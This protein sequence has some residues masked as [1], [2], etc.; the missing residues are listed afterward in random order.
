MKVP[1]DTYYSRLARS[2]NLEPLQPKAPFPSPESER[3]FR[4]LSEGTFT[5]VLRCN[6]EKHACQI[7]DAFEISAYTDDDCKE[8]TSR[9]TIGRRYNFSAGESNGFIPE[10]WM[11][12]YHREL[13]SQLN[14]RVL[15]RFFR[16][17]AHLLSS[18]LRMDVYDILKATFM[19]LGQW[20]DL[21]DAAIAIADASLNCNHPD[22]AVMR[23]EAGQA[24]ETT[25]RFAEAALVFKHIGHKLENND[26]TNSSGCI[27]TPL[28]HDYTAKA[29]RR[30][31]KKHTAANESFLTLKAYYKYYDYKGRLLDFSNAIMS[32]LW[33]TLFSLLTEIFDEYTAASDNRGQECHQQAFVALSGLLSTAGFSPGETESSKSFDQR[34]KT[35]TG[36]LHVY[37]KSSRQAAANALAQGIKESQSIEDFQVSLVKALDPQVVKRAPLSFA[38]HREKGGLP[39]KTQKDWK[40][41]T[42]TDMMSGLV[43]CN[44]GN[45]ITVFFGCD[46]SACRR[47]GKNLTT[48]EASTKCLH[49]PCHW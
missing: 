47:G 28:I 24:L 30:A 22:C 9:L 33:E 37:H 10:G 41:N 34:N 16:T 14:H 48:K 32:R 4:K 8:P 39:K 17:D 38:S 1:Q 35:F 6:K 25:G 15:H 18:G 43:G 11:V 46:N 42:R 26:L 19:R 23:I 12:I 5:L 2:A 13:L 36:Y 29:L 40:L 27:S 7:K 31:G 45:G 44:G 21:V 49:C 3:I 20:N